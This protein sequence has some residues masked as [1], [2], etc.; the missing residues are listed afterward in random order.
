MFDRLRCL[1][2]RLL[3][4]HAEEARTVARASRVQ[5]M[6]R[7][8]SVA[9]DPAERLIG[10]P[11]PAA[12]LARKKCVPIMPIPDLLPRGPE[13]SEIL[14]LQ[15][16]TCTFRRGWWPSFSSKPPKPHEIVRQLRSVQLPICMCGRRLPPVSRCGF[17]N[18]LGIPARG[19]RQT[20]RTSLRPSLIRLRS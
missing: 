1:F 20:L 19:L 3:A 17:R 13:S 15:R 9:D 16:L 8:G 6:D 18:L 7:A 11:N 5:R 12:P 10:A 14:K 4:H 2:P